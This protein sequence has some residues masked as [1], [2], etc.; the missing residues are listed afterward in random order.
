MKKFKT[1]LA[2]MVAVCLLGGA[3]VTPMEAAAAGPS[4]APASGPAGP[5]WP[6]VI[7]R[8]GNH[9]ILYQPQLKSWQRYRELVADTA[10]SITPQ[11]GKQILGVI[12]WKAETVANVSLRTR[13]EER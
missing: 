4:P 11:G 5:G 12:S 6:R 2:V 8:D 9:V 10:I 3:T 1:F 7:D 13:S